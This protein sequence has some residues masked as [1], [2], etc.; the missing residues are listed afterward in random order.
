MN[1]LA[2]NLELF[3]FLI[4]PTSPPNDFILRNPVTS[5][6]VY[7]ARIYILPPETPPQTK[8]LFLVQSAHSVAAEKLGHVHSLN[9]SRQ[10][11]PST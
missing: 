8:T 2:K 5:F 6:L 4:L 9:K 1:I 3:F 7:T 10:T 11:R